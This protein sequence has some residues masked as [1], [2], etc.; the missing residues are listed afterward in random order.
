MTF[1]DEL[2]LFPTA[3]F[4]VGLG[5]CALYWAFVLVGAIGI[6]AIEFDGLF[7]GAS[8]L[9][10]AADGALDAALEGAIDGA[11]EGVGEIGEGAAD[12]VGDAAGSKSILLLA[13]HTLALEKAP[14]TVVFSLLFLWSWAFSMAMTHYVVPAISLPSGLVGTGVF[15]GALAGGVALTNRCAQPMG[16]LFEVNQAATRVDTLGRACEIRTGKVTATFGQA[17][18]KDGG[19]GLVLEVR[20]DE[21]NTLKK[22]DEAL[23]ISF[24]SDAECYW[25]EP[26][27]SVLAD[28][29]LAHTFDRV[30][31][32]NTSRG[33][34]DASALAEREVAVA[35]EEEVESM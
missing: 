32:H 3:I 16:K 19:A 6:D 33:T 23:I 20:C 35:V 1:V 26:M 24:D 11:A 31:A 10:G 2:F 7:D 8:G 18:S 13:A 15:L 29:R 9:D 4:T 12:S 5:L 27:E 21:P 30:K 28:R 34:I 22:G 14:A 17:E 25:V